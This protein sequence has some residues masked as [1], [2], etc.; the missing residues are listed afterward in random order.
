MGTPADTDTTANRPAVL[1]ISSQLWL[2]LGALG[3]LWAL[4]RLMLVTVMGGMVAPETYLPTLALYL[5]NGAVFVACVVFS[6]LLERGRRLARLVLSAYVVILPAL[7][8]IPDLMAGPPAGGMPERDLLLSP[9]SAAV[10]LAA[11]AT[12]LMWLPPANAYVARG[13]V[14]ALETPDGSGAA[15]DREPSV[16][17]AAVAVLVIFGVI[18][19]LEA[20]LGLL[21]LTESIG[22]DAKTTPALVLFLTLGFV[23]VGN[24]ACAWA[25]RRGKPSVRP[26]LTV[27]SVAGLVLV[28]LAT[29]AAFSNVPASDPWAEAG[30][31]TV[32][33]LTVFSQGLPVVGSLVAVLLIWLPSARR[34]FR[35]SAEVLP[36]GTG[37]S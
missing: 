34:H 12:V 3:T 26:V 7:L 16:V 29:V 19:A 15:S 37:G 4:T 8:Y 11:A 28:V 18:A 5:A 10:V 35:R 30:L 14:R 27:I 20:A 17:T 1:A 25:V 21:L 9:A 31:P 6:K 24:L 33:L 22:S 2:L 23:A 13:G 32:I 36:A